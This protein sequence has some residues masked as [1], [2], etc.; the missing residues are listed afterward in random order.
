MTLSN[1]QSAFCLFTLSSSLTIPFMIILL[2]NNS[3]TYDS[4]CCSH[5]SWTPG[6][7]D[8]KVKFTSIFSVLVSIFICMLK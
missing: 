7:L 3:G 8:G 4:G 5:F 6:V 1:L 2:I